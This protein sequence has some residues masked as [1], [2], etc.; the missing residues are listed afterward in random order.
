MQ[1][2]VISRVDFLEYLDFQFEATGKPAERAGARA[3]CSNATRVPPAQHAA[4]GLGVLDRH[5]RPA[6]R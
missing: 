5:R 6:S 1:L 4:A 3:T 2:P